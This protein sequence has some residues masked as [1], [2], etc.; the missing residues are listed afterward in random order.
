MTGT[1]HLLILIGAGQMA[2][3]ITI[4]MAALITDSRSRSAELKRSFR[5][6]LT[7]VAELGAERRRLAAATA[8]AAH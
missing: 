7:Q 5:A 3:S 8:Q 4:S 2:V 1:D 6:F